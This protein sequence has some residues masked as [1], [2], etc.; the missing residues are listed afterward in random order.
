MKQNKFENKTVIGITGGV[1]SGK[2]T[3]LDFLAGYKRTEIILADE[4]GRD[5]MKIGGSIYDALLIHYGENILDEFGEIDRKK[6]AGI[7]FRDKESEKEINDIEHP[8]V[9]DEI[10][11]R[12][13]ESKA[14]MI[15][16]EA[17]L[18]KEGK[19]T[20]FCDEV[21][22]VHVDPE[23]RKKRLM[24]SRGYSEEQCERIMS[25]QM[26]DEEFIKMSDAVI[27]NSKDMFL[28]QQDLKEFLEERFPYYEREVLKC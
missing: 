22:F 23:I 21:W 25:L 18:L 12:I 10:K 20:D 14:R 28:V 4:V 24:E 17:A 13:E 5:L 15:F 9:Y 16:V 27:E 7:A 19:L 3:I 1:G 2:S 8:L 11:R 26:S 6:L